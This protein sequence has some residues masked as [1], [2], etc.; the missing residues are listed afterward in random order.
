MAV[1]Q[2]AESTTLHIKNM[3]CDRCIRVVREELEHLGLCVVEMQL[4]RVVVMTPEAGL[5]LDAVSRTLEANGF[6]L[7]QDQQAQLVERIKTT[8]LDLIHSG[9]LEE[10]H[11]NYSDYISRQVGRSYS[12]LSALFSQVENLTIEKY[13][14]LQKIE[15]TKELLVYDELTLSEIAYRL[16]YSSPQYLSGQFKAVTGLTPTAFRSGKA[17]RRPLDHVTQ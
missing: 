16:G 7:L 6:E 8:I 2:V 4:G 11:L 15:K 5:D 10:L 12:Y 17:K 14:I 13:L 1:A 9:G 3:V